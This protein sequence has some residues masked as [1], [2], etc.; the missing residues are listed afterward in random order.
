MSNDVEAIKA[1]LRDPVLFARHASGLKL[2]N[3]QQDATRAIVD[4]VVHRRGLTFVVIMSRQAG[5]NEL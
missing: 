3:Y 5:K 2:R 1:L 4:S